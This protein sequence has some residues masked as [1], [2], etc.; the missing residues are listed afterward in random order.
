MRAALRLL[1]AASVLVAAGCGDAPA[2]PDALPPSP[3][4]ST[5]SPLP[6]PDTGPP[7]GEVV[8][9]LRQS[10]RD[11]ALGRFQVWVGNGLGEPV[12]PTSVSYV[13]PR[14]R[15][16]LPG[17]RLREIPAGSE[18]GFTLAQP[19][20]PACGAGAG[21]ARLLLGWAGR[22][23]V[24]PVEDEADVVDRY[25]TGRCL[26]LDVAR[27]A[28]LSFAEEVRSVGGEGAPG[29]LVLVVEPTGRATERGSRLTIDTVTGTPVLTAAGQSFWSPG[30]TVRSDGPR[31][32][33]PLTVQPARCDGH[34]FAES[35]GAT[36]FRVRLTLDGEPGEL[37][38]RMSPAGAAAAL[39]FARESCGLN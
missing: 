31:V 16:P 7:A 30:V 25:V 10:S 3:S 24:V 14:F 37:V 11:A 15:G 33:V 32:A 19:S 28:R 29:T 2:A 5:L 12:T 38:V 9:D 18:R 21:Q 27:V 36:A 22:R 8:A 13:D 26:E 1:L 4:I 34:V 35:G 20:R 6:M 17:G 23:L 39:A